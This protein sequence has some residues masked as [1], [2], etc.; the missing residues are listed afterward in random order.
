MVSKNMSER[1]SF[2]LNRKSV[3]TDHNKGF[4]LNKFPRDTKTASSGNY[5]RNWYEMLSNNQIISF[6]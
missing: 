2:P 3:S 5:L 1:I 6:H 4:S